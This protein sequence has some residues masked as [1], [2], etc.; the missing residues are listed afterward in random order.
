VLKYY[1]WAIAEKT[2]S[3]VPFGPEFYH[4]VGYLAHFQSNARFLSFASSFPLI[5]T[6]RNLLPPGGTVIDLGTGW[7]HHD[8]FLLRLVTDCVIH[9]FDVED[10]AKLVFIRNYL[11]HLLTN[12]HGIASELGIEAQ[13]VVRKLKPL[14]DLNTRQEI[15]NA[16]NFVPCITHRTDQPFLPEGTVDMMV[17]N[18]VLT[19]IPPNLLIPELI[20]LRRML[21]D[22]GHMYMLV[23]HEDHWAFHDPSANQFNYYRYSDRLYRQI[24]ETKMEYQ[25]RFVKSEWEKIF[26]QV[27]LRIERYEATI[28]DK[29]RAQIRALPHVDA[30]FTQYSLDE[31]ATIYSYFLLCKGSEVTL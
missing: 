13:T 12:A 31:L 7:F 23:G 29:S 6:A 10:K 25:N 26:E 4:T 17:S 14:L 8:A 21:K 20:A 16:S 28:T 15:Y 30:R 5:R 19:H 2:L 18:C 3:H 24:F 11:Q 27:G 9:L 1:L 22:D